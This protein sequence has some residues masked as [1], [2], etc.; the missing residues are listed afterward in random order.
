M[1]RQAACAYFFVDAARHAVA[2]DDDLVPVGHGVHIGAGQRAFGLEV[3]HDLG[4]VDQR[5]QRGDFAPLGQQVV[6]EFDG[7]VHPKA[8][9]GGLG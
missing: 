4:V 3:G 1:I 9:T 8:E 7:A 5:P 6:G 2:A